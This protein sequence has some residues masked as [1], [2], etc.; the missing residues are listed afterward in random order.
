MALSRSVIASLLLLASLIITPSVAVACTCMAFPDD[1]A[2][3][4]AMA[5]AQADVIFLG[6]VTDIKTKRWQKPIGVRETTF[7]LLEV[8]KGLSGRNPA[9]VSSAIGSL[10]C[11]Y[12]FDKPGKYLVIAYWDVERQVLSGSLTRSGVAPTT[13]PDSNDPKLDSRDTGAAHR[14]R[15]MDTRANLRVRLFP[16]VISV[17]IR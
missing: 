4:A 6:T 7:E 17:L 16:F 2:K 9:V 11:G 3:A 15:I 13:R 10:A 12:K 1:D 5:Y 14:M 8:W